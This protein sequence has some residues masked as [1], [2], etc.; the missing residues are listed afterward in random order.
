MA[1][2]SFSSL[3]TRRPRM[4]TALVEPHLSREPVLPLVMTFPRGRDL[5]SAILFWFFSALAWGGLATALVFAW[6]HFWP[7]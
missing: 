7:S 3:L 6:V 5:V 2:A 1:A 4:K